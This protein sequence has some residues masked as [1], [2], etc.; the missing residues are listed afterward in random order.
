MSKTIISVADDSVGAI[1]VMTGKQKTRFATNLDAAALIGLLQEE[2]E[3]L[4]AIVDTL[5]KTA[6]GV[7]I[8]RGM[9]LFRVINDAISE[10]GPVLC[11]YRNT[12][13]FERGFESAVNW[14]TYYA[15]REAAEAG[16][17]ID[18][19]KPITEDHVVAKK[20]TLDEMRKIAADSLSSGNTPKD[21]LE[22][23][24]TGEIRDLKSGE[25]ATILTAVKA[26][27][28]GEEKQPTIGELIESARASMA[29][30]GFSSKAVEKVFGAA[31]K[32]A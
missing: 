5:P 9:T 7:P 22:W 13:L 4:L 23:I 1:T 2:I 18:P 17:D 28:F 15:T 16:R 8:V 12:L 14:D 11:A 24:R 20:M 26:A 19:L 25:I 30:G 21:I 29:M 6:D 32:L 27:I 10:V 3:R 31:E